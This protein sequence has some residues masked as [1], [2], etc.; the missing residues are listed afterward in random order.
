MNYYRRYVGDYLRDT[1]RL[2]VLE[3]GA[4]NLM[5]DYYYAD[6][7]PLPLDKAEL[8]TMVRAMTPADR[9]AVDRVLE[10]YFVEAGDGYHNNRA[11]HEIE[12]SRKA[13]DNGKGGGRPPK[14]ETGTGTGTITDEETGEITGLENESLTGDGGGSVHPPTTN[15]QPPST[16]LQPPA[17]IK[18][19]ALSRPNGHD[20]THQA[21]EILEYLNRSSGHA[22]R[23]VDTNLKPIIARLDSGATPLQIK[24]VILHKCDQWRGNAEMAKY[25]RPETLFRPTK[26]EGY[27]GEIGG[28]SDG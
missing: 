20:R 18:S 3:H 10:R 23:A 15:H 4:Y 1:S 26:F 21:K 17:S 9:K 13:R 5:L 28:G 11:D 2:S 24:E 27:L 12:V 16:T 25:L 22:Y 14:G 8:Y 6:E 19:K 7:R